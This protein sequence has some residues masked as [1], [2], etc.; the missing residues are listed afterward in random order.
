MLPLS[1]INTPFSTMRKTR[2]PTSISCAR[3]T[4]SHKG[5]SFRLVVYNLVLW[6]TIQWTNVYAVPE[7]RQTY[8]YTA[9]A[10]HLEALQWARANGTPE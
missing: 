10:G 7:N 4:R 2:S 3:P 1:C 6:Y 8:T 5:T 9:V